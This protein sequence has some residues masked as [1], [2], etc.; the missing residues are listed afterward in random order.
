MC[1]KLERTQSWEIVEKKAQNQLPVKEQ[2]LGIACQSKLQLPAQEPTLD[3]SQL[4]RLG[5]SSRKCLSRSQRSHWDQLGQSLNCEVAKAY[6]S[7]QS[8]EKACGR[9]ATG[10]VNPET[11]MGKGLY[12]TTQQHCPSAGSGGGNT[13]CMRAVLKEKTCP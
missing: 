3:C 5:A 13:I 6:F 7:S 2:F 11:N 1:L 8:S 9:P 4:L 10:S 12:K